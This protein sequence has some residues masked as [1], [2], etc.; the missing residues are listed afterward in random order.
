M[1]IQL[2]EFWKVKFEKILSLESINAP[3]AKYTLGFMSFV[4]VFKTI[5]SKFKILLPITLVHF[6][7]SKTTSKAGIFPVIHIKLLAT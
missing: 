2:H 5:L 6:R 4:V 7:K 3:Q 1:A